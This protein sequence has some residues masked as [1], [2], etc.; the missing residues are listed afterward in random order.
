M[1]NFIEVH[2][3]GEKRLFNTNRIIA[4]EK[5]KDY[6]ATIFLGGDGVI[7]DETYNEILRKIWSS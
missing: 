1:N 3:N 7:V 6:T 4:V 2:V 5:N